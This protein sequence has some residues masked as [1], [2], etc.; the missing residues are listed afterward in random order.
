MQLGLLI[1]IHFGSS[2]AQKLCSL[3]WFATM[4]DRDDE[5][6]G[7]LAALSEGEEHSSASE[8]FA[9]VP[10]GRARAVGHV[11]RPRE[12]PRSGGAEVWLISEQRVGASSSSGDVVRS[13]AASQVLRSVA[14]LGRITYTFTPV[15]AS[16]P[17]S[18]VAGGPDADIRGRAQ[19]W[20]DLQY[21]L[22]EMWPFVDEHPLEDAGVVDR[23][24]SP[25]LLLEACRHARLADTGGS[26]EAFMNKNPALHFNTHVVLRREDLYRLMDAV[27]PRVFKSVPLCLR[28]DWSALVPGVPRKSDVNSW[29]RVVG[30]KRRRRDSAEVAGEPAPLGE[31]ELLWF[32]PRF[33]GEKRA[34]PGGRTNRPSQ[35]Q[36]ELDPLKL[37]NAVSFSLHLRQV[38]SFSDALADARRYEHEELDDDAVEVPRDATADPSRGTLDRAKARIDA[39]G[40]NVQRRQ[41]HAE[42]AK[43]EIVGINCHAD[44]S[45]VTGSEIQGMVLDFCKTD[46]RVRRIRCPGATLSYSMT[47]TINKTVVFLWSVR[48]VCGPLLSHMQYFVSKVICFTTD[49]GVE[50]CIPD[51]P[52]L[53]TAFIAWVDGAQLLAIRELIN[54]N[55]RLFYRCIRVSGWSHAAGNLM[56]TVMKRAP[57]YPEYLD[58]L[59]HL[60]QFFRNDTWTYYL[61][62]CLSDRI[63]GLSQKLAHG[64]ASPASGGLKLGRS[65]HMTSSNTVT[66]ARPICNPIC[67]STRKRRNF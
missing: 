17:G 48:L 27:L 38:A 34:G 28:N 42:M 20:G 21:T 60:C 29:R 31:H 54:F 25:L 53:L 8:H 62:R 57:R 44:S 16:A 51:S 43:D 47:D 63:P 67:L 59:R 41:F 50:S 32:P 55:R 52:D 61:D 12:A 2:S 10:E 35:L 11:G 30:A 65:A 39:I 14:A 66:F 45:P 46:K 19:R 7:S 5:R 56:K 9:V 26:V 36:R 13:A 64:C 23:A 15:V 49:F 58:Y 37:V 18:V 4:A 33:S 1:R 6:F 40:M 24:T 3:G 22:E